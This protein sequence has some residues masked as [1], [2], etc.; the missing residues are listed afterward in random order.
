MKKLLFVINNLNGG[1]AE[2]ALL[3]LA[4]ILKKENYDITILLIER[5]GI[6]IKEAEKEFKI[7]NIFN[8]RNIFNKIKIF[9][10]INTAYR[11]YFIKYFYKYILEKKLQKNYDVVI[12]FLEGISTEL[13][14]EIKNMKKIAWIHTDLS[15]NNIHFSLKEQRK[16]YEKIDKIVCVSNDTKEKFLNLHSCY[17]KKTVVIYNYIDKDEIIDKS[18]EK[19]IS[20]NK[21]LIRII[22]VGRLSKEK[23]HNLLL[24]AL[25]NINLPNKNYEVEILGDGVKRKEY[26]KY[27]LENNLNDKVKLL[28][29][30]KNPYL[31][32]RNADIFIMPSYYEGYPLVLCEAMTLGKAII[33]SDCGSALEILENGKYGMIFKKGDSLDLKYKIEKMININDHVKLYSVLSKLGSQNFDKEKILKNIKNLFKN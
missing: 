13:I 1:G 33:S 21:N 15:K 2:K 7:L 18:L 5:E 24:E 27:I 20:K 26:E 3:V 14:S 32:I 31:Y 30:K 16:M 25:T 28:G 17:N 9:R 22:S 4:K 23:G 19:K 10:K 29:F 8:K 12:S 11:I 6:Y